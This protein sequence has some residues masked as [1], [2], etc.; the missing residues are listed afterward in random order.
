MDLT[1]TGPPWTFQWVPLRY[2]TRLLGIGTFDRGFKLGLIL[3]ITN[4]L[5][6]KGMVTY[7]MGV[8]CGHGLSDLLAKFEQKWA[9][10][11]RL[12]SHSKMAAIF[13]VHVLCISAMPYLMLSFLPDIGQP[14]DAA[15]LAHAPTLK[16][17]WGSALAQP[18]HI[19]LSAINLQYK[20]ARGYS[21]TK[22]CE[23]DTKRA[24]CWHSRTPP[25]FMA[26]GRKIHTVAI[27]PPTLQPSSQIM[28]WVKCFT[29]MIGV[30]I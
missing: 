23:E 9:L 25:R 20:H 15:S 13:N 1:E 19:F 29:L 27:L 2:R 24:V 7:M 21:I 11:S 14:P 30:I 16:G 26:L 5:K 28:V 6:M 17:Q 22:G 18:P 4:N 8:A 12:L 10:S 3:L